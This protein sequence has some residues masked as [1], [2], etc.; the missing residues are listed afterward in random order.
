MPAQRVAAVTAVARARAGKVIAIAARVENE[1]RKNLNAGVVE[2]TAHHGLMVASNVV[3]A[4][5]SD[6]RA[7]A[8]LI[9]LVIVVPR[10]R[11]ARPAPS[12]TV[13]AT[14]V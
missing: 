2:K 3:K 9:L 12:L 1:V 4:A 7:I 6:V 11:V 10:I 14:A 5:S 13:V 8:V